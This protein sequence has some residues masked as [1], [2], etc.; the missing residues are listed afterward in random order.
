MLIKHHLG[1]PLQST[2]VTLSYGIPIP[3]QTM[4]LVDRAIQLLSPAAED[5]CREYLTRLIDTE[6]AMFEG[7]LNLQADRLE[8]LSLRSDYI[9]RLMDNYQ[10]WQQRLATIIG[11]PINPDFSGVNQIFSG[12]SN[13]RVTH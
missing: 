1:Y 5:L 4:F 3:T 2:S 6:K 13:A 8:D 9:P 10:L 12:I 7:Q 11:V